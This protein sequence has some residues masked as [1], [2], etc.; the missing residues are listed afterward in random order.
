VTPPLPFLVQVDVHRYA[1]VAGDL[2]R[3]GD[4]LRTNG[5]DALAD[6][7]AYAAQVL[8][9]LSVLLSR[10]AETLEEGAAT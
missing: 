6:E 10:R 5:E 7:Y 8:S 9:V 2:K 3:R 4:Y 1:K